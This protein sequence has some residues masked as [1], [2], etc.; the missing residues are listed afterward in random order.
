MKDFLA[1]HIER[2]GSIDYGDLHEEELNAN[3]GNIGLKLISQESNVSNK[4]L[5]PSKLCSK[6]NNAS[7]SLQ[8]R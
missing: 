3:A 1:N 8:G 2:L 5:K 6:M 4:E 7:F